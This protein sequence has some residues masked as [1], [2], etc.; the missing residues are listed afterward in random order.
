MGNSLFGNKKPV[1]HEPPAN[2]LDRHNGR[3]ADATGIKRDV[4][5]RLLLDD[6]EML[7]VITA[8]ANGGTIAGALKQIRGADA[9]A[10]FKTMRRKPKWR[11]IFN[12]IKPDAALAMMDSLRQSALDALAADATNPAAIAAL[13]KV[14]HPMA[15]AFDA[16]TWGDRGPIA[17]PVTL[18]VHTNL[19]DDQTGLLS[20]PAA[21]GEVSP[22]LAGPVPAPHRL[23]R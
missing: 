15:K 6:A 13:A 4:P 9:A 17:A 7:N 8:L 14:T 1:L 21:L 20:L 5:K 16:P 18:V 2:K 12:A 19:G 11:T 22:R 10:F 3:R 23:D